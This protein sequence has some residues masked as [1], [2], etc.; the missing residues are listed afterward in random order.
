MQS[1]G[2]TRSGVRAMIA[3]QA[4]VVGVAGL[5]VGVPIGLI[6]GRAGWQAITDRVPLTFRSPLTAIA[7]VV[8][9]PSALIAANLLAIIPARR[10]SKVQPAL[11]LRSE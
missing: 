3:A 1:L 7:V 6:A 8:V 5:L 2:V 4:T 11:V 10:A 9:I